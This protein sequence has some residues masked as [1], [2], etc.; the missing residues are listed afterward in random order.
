MT[1]KSVR[2]GK[3]SEFQLTSLLLLNPGAPCLLCKGGGDTEPARKPEKSTL[4]TKGKWQAAYI[5]QTV[6]QAL[7]R[8]AVK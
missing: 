7:A 6:S 8:L 1:L 2:T 4:V 5:L 3:T